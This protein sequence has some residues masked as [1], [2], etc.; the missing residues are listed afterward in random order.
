MYIADD[1]LVICC[2]N[3]I[4]VEKEDRTISTL[5][6]KYIYP[7]KTIERCFYNKE[8]ERD[9]MFDFIVKRLC[10]DRFILQETEK[11]E[12][13]DKEKIGYLIEKALLAAYENG[14]A[15]Y[16]FRVCNGLGKHGEYKNA[17]SAAKECGD[18]V[19]DVYEALG[20]ERKYLQAKSTE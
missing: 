9:A 18:A 2:D 8:S 4:G 7:D 3:L 6:L 14:E 10:D 20:T 16:M 11:V 17:T 5:Y 1:K 19:A 12:P 15:S 13:I